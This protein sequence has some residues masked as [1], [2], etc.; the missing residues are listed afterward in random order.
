M[1]R[2]KFNGIKIS[3]IVTTVGDKE[4]KIEEEAKNFGYDEKTLKRLKKTIGFNSR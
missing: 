2:L 3:A 4:V 1:A